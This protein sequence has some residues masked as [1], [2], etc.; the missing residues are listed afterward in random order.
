MTR[1]QEA[2]CGGT[3]LTH[4]DSPVPRCSLCSRSEQPQP[5]GEPMKPPA[6]YRRRDPHNKGKGHKKKAA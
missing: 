5:G 2:H 1:C 3:L 4:L 6:V